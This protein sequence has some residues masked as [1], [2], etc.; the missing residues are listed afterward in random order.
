VITRCRSWTRSLISI[1]TLASDEF[2]IGPDVESGHR[3]HH[4]PATRFGFGLDDPVPLTARVEDAKAVLADGMG[5][6]AHRGNS[7]TRSGP[8]PES[9]SPRSRTAIVGAIIRGGRRVPMRH[10]FRH[11]LHSPSSRLMKSGRTG[12]RALGSPRMRPKIWTLGRS[13]GPASDDPEDAHGNV[14]ATVGVLSERLVTV[15]QRITQLVM[16]GVRRHRLHLEQ[17]PSDSAAAQFGGQSTSGV[18]SRRG[19]RSSNTSTQRATHS[20]QMKIPL[21][22]PINR[23]SSCDLVQKEQ[24]AG[25][26]SVTVPMVDGRR[27]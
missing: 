4:A 14:G 13:A 1:V 27:Q 7:P 19:G 10:S 11:H 18:T 12:W 22:P 21:G 6:G 5:P 26:R 25:I 9:L 17:M 23:T 16:N 8:M 15:V 2:G 20:S 3:S 24:R